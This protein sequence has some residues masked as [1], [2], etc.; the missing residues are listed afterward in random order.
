[1]TVSRGEVEVEE[2]EE[3]EVSFCQTYSSFTSPQDK[4][5]SVF[6][7]QTLSPLRSTLVR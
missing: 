1:M 6:L 5:T 2:E 3:D 4:L 7:L